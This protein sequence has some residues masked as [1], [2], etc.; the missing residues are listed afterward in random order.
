MSMLTDW[1]N[2]ECY[3]DIYSYSGNTN[4]N[5]ILPGLQKRLLEQ[6]I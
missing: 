3:R 5:I 1:G 6:V 4:R 2:N